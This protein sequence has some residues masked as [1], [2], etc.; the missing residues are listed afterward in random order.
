MRHVVRLEGVPPAN[1]YSHAV[2][3]SGR[4]T[5]TSTD[6]R[7]RHSPHRRRVRGSAFLDTDRRPATAHPHAEMEPDLTD[8]DHDAGSTR[9]SNTRTSGA[10]S[11]GQN[12]PGATGVQAEVRAPEHHVIS[13]AVIRRYLNDLNFYD[14]GG[15]GRTFTRRSRRRGACWAIR[16]Q[17]GCSGIGSP[18]LRR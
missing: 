1:G 7:P 3:A 9:R 15:A 6:P 2:V 16:I 4:P 13:L 17:D 14:L 5:T 8:I 11:H 12:H 10:Q 18:R